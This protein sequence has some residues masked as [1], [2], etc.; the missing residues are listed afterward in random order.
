MT[1]NVTAA[2]AL[3]PDTRKTREVAPLRVLFV[4]NRYQIPGG[5]DAA[6]EREIATLR[7]TGVDVES[8]ILDNSAI[9]TSFDRLRV[10]V[11][12]PHA[13]QGIATVVE[14]ARRFRPDVVH[15]H[16]TFPLISPA[17]H[18]AVRELGA[19][20]VQTLHNFR[21]MCANGLLLREGS[22]CERCVSGSPFQS[23]RFGCYRGS[24]V[25]TLAVARMIDHHRRAG[26]WLRDVDRFI[27]LSAFARDRFLAAGLPA[28]RLSIKPNGID[29]PGPVATGQ[30]SGILF[31]GR[32]S[33]EKGVRVL[34]EAAALVSH[35]ITVIGDGPLMPELRNVNGLRLLGQ[36]NREAVRAAMS[37]AAAVVVPSICYEG[38]PTVI[39]EAF[40]AGTPVVASRIGAMPE[41]INEGVTGLLAEP[42]DAASLSAA[43]HQIHDNPKQARRMGIAARAVFERT[44]VNDIVTAQTLAIYRE[45]I[46]S[47]A[48]D[49]TFQASA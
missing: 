39:P 14:A 48:A 13:P 32:L 38:L 8:V 6:V 42:G 47:R 2:M 7:A 10:A 12:T 5:E 16:N 11:Q 34:A 43:L 19:A 1:A 24:K 28:A 45:A 33:E 20:T 36:Q 31:V 49:R 21:L 25:G 40:A 44:W 17:V 30:R 18:G 35:P 22:P 37:R 4:H 29:D 46:A 9:Q 41:L 3:S 23:V 27:V 15:V 26:T